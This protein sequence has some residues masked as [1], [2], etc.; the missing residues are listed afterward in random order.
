M[1]VVVDSSLVVAALIGPSADQRWARQVIE[2]GALAAPHLMPVEVAHVL[3]KATLSRS[4]SADATGMAHRDL[5]G[6]RVELFPYAPCAARV[7]SLRAN[8]STYDAWFVALAELLNCE[9]ATVDH[10]LV[11]ASGPRCEFLS[12][13]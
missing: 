12:P 4:L 2:G 3:R 6:L 8:I 13:P 9:L 1:T 7:W 11:R 5:L 10:R